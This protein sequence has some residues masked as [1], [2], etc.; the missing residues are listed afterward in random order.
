MMIFSLRF[1]GPEEAGYAMCVKSISISP[2]ASFCQPSF[3]RSFSR[4]KPV[5]DNRANT[6]IQTLL[7]CPTPLLNQMIVVGSLSTLSLSVWHCKLLMEAKEPGST[8]ILCHHD[9][10]CSKVTGYTPPMTMIGSG[11]RK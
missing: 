7:W 2:Q 5:K 11:N 4:S 3:L 1:G 9:S 10:P 8:G 6:F